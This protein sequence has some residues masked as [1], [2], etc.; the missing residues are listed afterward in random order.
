MGVALSTSLLK[1]KINLLIFFVDL[2][3]LSKINYGCATCS[4]DALSTFL[5]YSSVIL[6]SME[7]MMFY[8]NMYFS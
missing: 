2:I 5:M 4:S 7:A 8:G 6:D 3:R 1:S